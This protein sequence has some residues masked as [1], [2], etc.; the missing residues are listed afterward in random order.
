MAKPKIAM[1]WLAG[2]GGCEE[3]I[4]DLGEDLLT[5]AARGILKHPARADEAAL[6]DLEMVFRAYDPCM[7]CATH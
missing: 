3:S 5:L 2:C 6:N 1:Y 4:L 7:A